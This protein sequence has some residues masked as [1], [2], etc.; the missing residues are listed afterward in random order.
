MGLRKATKEELSFL[1]AILMHQLDLD[2]FI[3]EKV[4][5]EEVLVKV[6]PRTG[7]IRE[8]FLP[9][10]VKVASLRA[11][12]FTLNLTLY[13]AK[14][15]K[16]YVKPMKLRV[17]V[18]NEISQDILANPTNVFAKHVID[19]DNE[20]RAGDEVMVVNES[21]DLLCV[22][23]M[24]LSPYEIMFFTRGIAVRIRECVRYASSR[25]SNI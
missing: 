19:V 25:S 3:A 13:A 7:K 15:I 24:L 2:P 20:L 14:V 11:S 5:P 21:D 4:L 22:G 6:S 17:C 8:I 16:S 18:V 23:R 12:S 1:R 9:S 10:G